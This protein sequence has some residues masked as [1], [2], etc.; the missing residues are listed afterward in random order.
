MPQTREFPH[1][2]FTWKGS[3]SDARTCSISRRSRIGG[4]SGNRLER[5]AEPH[6]DEHVP[7]HSRGGWYIWRNCRKDDDRREHACPDDTGVPFGIGRAGTGSRASTG[8][9]G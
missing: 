3:I 4:P 1:T 8:G 7:E 2:V 5:V 6:D 9:S